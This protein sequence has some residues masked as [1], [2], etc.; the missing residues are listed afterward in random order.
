M[1]LN[2]N[3]NHHPSSS[4]SS[5][6]SKMAPTHCVECVAISLTN[7]LIMSY[8]DAQN[9]RSL[10]TFN[11][12]I[13]QH[14]ISVGSL[15]QNY[16]IIRHLQ[17]N[18]MNTN[19]KL[20]QKMNNPKPDIIIR[21]HTNQR[22]WIITGMAVPS[23]RNI[24]VKVVEKVSKSL[25]RLKI[26]IARMWKMETETYQLL[27]AHLGSLRRNWKHTLAQPALHPKK[28]SVNQVNCSVS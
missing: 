20:L 6:S 18:G 25:Y 9:W 28:G 11:D 8:L 16:N 17:T 4:L 3:N 14:H 13:T 2:Y 23:D 10:N 7:L 19:Q 22:C 26:E 15:C 5:S 1:T 21:D 24:S 27:L 12:M